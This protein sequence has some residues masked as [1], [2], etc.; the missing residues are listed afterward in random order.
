[1]FLIEKT[2]S[3]F[4]KFTDLKK[5]H[6]TRGFKLQKV[7][8]PTRHNWSSLDEGVDNRS[9][10]WYLQYGI[11]IFQEKNYK[12]YFGVRCI[13]Y[14]FPADPFSPIVLFLSYFSLPIEH[15]FIGSKFNFRVLFSV[16]F[17]AACVVD[18][19]DTSAVHCILDE[20]RSHCNG[21]VRRTIPRVEQLNCSAAQNSCKGKS[22]SYGYLMT[23][24]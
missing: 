12:L 23:Y 9:Y 8:L 1:M 10:R 17:Q 6:H 3:D 19:E 15:N 7:S 13:S 11:E 4:G 24:R 16:Y 14:P 20:R 21:P 22:L 2:N 18:N 5:I